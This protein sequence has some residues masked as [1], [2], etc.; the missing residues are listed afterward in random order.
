MILV[1]ILIVSQD[2]DASIQL[3]NELRAAGDKVDIVTPGMGAVDLGLCGDYDAAFL[4]DKDAET[5]ALDILER[6]RRDAVKLPVIVLS[7]TDDWRFIAASL[8]NGADQVVVS[9]C[10]PAYCCAMLRATLRR[11]RWTADAAA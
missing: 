7:T 2:P 5:P 3:K 8:D 10:E 4:D 9:P 6:W 1:R 11:A